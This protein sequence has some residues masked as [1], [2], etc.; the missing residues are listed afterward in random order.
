VPPSRR[1]SV[2]DVGVWGGGR[3]ASD[4]GARVSV[5]G[6]LNRWGAAAGRGAGGGGGG[7]LPQ[8]HRPARAGGRAVVWHGRV[9][10]DGTQGQRP[11]SGCPGGPRGPGGR[12]GAPAAGP[13]PSAGRRCWIRRRGRLSGRVGG[14]PRTVAR[15]PP[16]VGRHGR[17]LS[18]SR[19]GPVF[20]GVLCLWGGRGRWRL[21]R[22]VRPAGA[23]AVGICWAT[24]RA[25]AAERGGGGGVHARRG[26]TRAR[27]RASVRRGAPAGAVGHGR[28]GRCC[29]PR[30]LLG[31]FGGGEG[32]SCAAAD[33]DGCLWVGGR[34]W[35]SAAALQAVGGRRALGVGGARGG[36]PPRWCRSGRAR[37][38]APCL[39]T[40]G[41]RGAVERRF[42]FLSVFFS[43][44]T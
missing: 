24:V 13:R 21:L 39:G 4:G 41:A 37:C 44:A 11:P 3:A 31:V 17:S 25:R 28:G 8:R 1:G 33:G 30:H 9:R 22:R 29:P 34:G 12:S 35:V 38:A 32:G 26:A 20:G 10:P 14:R 6:T 40:G 19:L 2:V 16:P 18:R 5:R 23:G 7:G 42:F 43:V 27:V 36:D 15:W